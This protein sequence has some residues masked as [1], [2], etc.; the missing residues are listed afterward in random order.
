[1][2]TGLLL[3]CLGVVIGWLVPEPQWAQ[4]FI[5]DTI[6]TVKGWFGPK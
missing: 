3:I 1:M 5:A 6:Y 4:D 2:I